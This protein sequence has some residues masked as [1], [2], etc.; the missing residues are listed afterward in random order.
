MTDNGTALNPLVSGA[1]AAFMRG[2]KGS[3]YD[4]GHRVPCFMRWTGML[5]AGKDVTPIAAHIDIVPTLI[6]LCGHK[7]PAGVAF[8][9]A[10]LRPLL[11]GKGDWPARTLLVH[12][13]RIDHPEKWR[14]SAVMTDRWRLINGTELYDMTVDPGQKKD[15]AQDRPNEVAELRRA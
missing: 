3:E 14:K 10:S 11:M 6:D 2:F 7:K 1:F 15:V 8:D 5:P 12:S 13:Q 9:G 4:G